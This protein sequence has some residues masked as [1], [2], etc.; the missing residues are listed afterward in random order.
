M[1]H[2]GQKRPGAGCPQ[3]FT[4]RNSLSSN[5]GLNESREGKMINFPACDQSFMKTYPGSVSVLLCIAFVLAT[6]CTNQAIPPGSTSVSQTPAPVPV[7][8]TLMSPATV[9]STTLQTPALTPSPIALDKITDGF[10]C[11]DTTMNIG[12]APTNVRECYQ[13]LTDGTF[14]WGYSPGYAM[15]RSPSCW[16][17]DVRCTYILNSKGQYEVSGGYSYTLTGDTL[18]DP[19][20][21]PYFTRSFTGIP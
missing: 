5:G 13:F 19:H 21:P 3:W 16:S 15:G 12:K 18:I 8:T 7:T 17:P 9:Q 10:W 6:G 14:R 20:D 11:R 2:D 1:R 4:I